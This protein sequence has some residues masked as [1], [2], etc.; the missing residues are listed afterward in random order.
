MASQTRSA[1]L[2][3]SIV[4]G[5]IPWTTPTNIYTSNNVYAWAGLSRNDIT[6]WLRATTFGFAIPDGAT[7]DGIVVEIEKKATGNGVIDNSVKIVAAG[8]EQGDEKAAAG[9]WSTTESYISY[10]GVDD[11]WGLGWNSAGINASNFGVSII[12]RHTL[13]DPQAAYVDHIRITVYYTEVALTNMKINIADTFKDVEE[14]KINI[15]DS[16]KT[17]TK[18]QIN[19]GDVWK[20]IFG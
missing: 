6:Y 1:G 7:I 8:S 10:G 9:Y 11:L 4:S 2:G 13:T 17:V 20:T 18:I 14:V 19:I 15:G 16:W 12:A 3:Q 5:N